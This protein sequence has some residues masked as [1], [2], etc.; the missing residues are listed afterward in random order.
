MAKIIVSILMS[1]SVLLSQN[2]G[3]TNE[4]IVVTLSYDIVLERDFDS[5]IEIPGYGDFAA[6]TSV[7]L[8]EQKCFL[9]KS[10]IPIQNISSP[11]VRWS[12]NSDDN[13]LI[14]LLGVKS[15]YEKL[16]I[17]LVLNSSVLDVQ[18]YGRLLYD[19]S[20]DNAIILLPSSIESKVL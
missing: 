2:D 6:V 9:T 8:D 10:K 12:Q 18:D 7:E 20:K 11:T 5:I 15:R 16:K 19:D 17:K 13:I 1:V 14:N 3:K 4:Y